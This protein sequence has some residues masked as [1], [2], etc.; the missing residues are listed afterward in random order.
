M[1]AMGVG[2]VAG[3]TLTANE[4][5]EG[6]FDGLHSFRAAGFNVGS[7]LMVVATTNQIADSAGGHED[8]DGGIAIDSVDG[9]Q[10]ALMDDG[11][12]GE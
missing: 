3:D 2:C 10:E 5:S 4:F 12:Q 6:L 8:F 11:Q 9:G 1:T 7:E